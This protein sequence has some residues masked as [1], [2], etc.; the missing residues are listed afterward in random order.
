[1]DFHLP[2]LG[3]GVYEAEMVRWLVNPGDR[4]HHGQGLMEVMT[5]KATMEVPA[6]FAGTVTELRVQ[7]GQTIKVGD[8]ILSYT[9][10]GAVAEEHAPPAPPAVPL[11]LE[12]EPIRPEPDRPA[13]YNGLAREMG[14]DDHPPVPVK[15]SP[16]VR[17]LARK[18]GIDL[19]AVHGSGPAGRILID[20]LHLSPTIPGPGHGGPTVPARLPA[21]ARLDYGRAGTVIKLAGVRRRIAEHLVHTK[22]TVPHFTY[23]DECDVTDLVKLRASLRE[24]FER[25]GIRLTYLPFFVK[26]AVASLKEVPIV[27]S[28]L[29]DATGEISLHDRYHIGIAT[30]TPSGLLVPVVRDAD[31]KDLATIAR[32]IERL[33]AEARAGRSR[34][35][36]LRGS[37]FTITSI[38]GIG[39]LLATPIINHPEV[40]ILGVGRAVKRPVFDAAGNIKAA[41]MIYLSLSFDHRVVDGAVGAVFGNAL[42]K[43]LQNP[44]R[45][46]LSEK[47]V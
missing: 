3:E 31:K 47:L 26:A 23:V 40:A 30:A 12:S 16:S 15:A 2:Q 34:L 4:V 7:P 17:L 38:G 22:H 28:S 36:D 25:H 6:P 14:S 37:T 18:L 13:D 21:A 1:M 11:P 43:Q 27:N 29:N 46:L 19:R 10:S 45:L 33:S 24:P 8:L 5:D 39:G 35:E 44:A 41:E 9:P 42:I 20:D 32:D